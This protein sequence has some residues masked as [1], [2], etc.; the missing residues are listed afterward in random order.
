MVYSR[1]STNAAAADEGGS[2]GGSHFQKSNSESFSEIL[3]ELQK[4]D[5][6]ILIQK[7]QIKEKIL[8]KFCSGEISSENVEFIL[9]NFRTIFYE[10]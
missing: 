2:G 9:E 8:L 5:S 1:I 10:F 6:E 4:I 7:I 3:N